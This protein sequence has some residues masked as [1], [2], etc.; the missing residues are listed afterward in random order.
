MKTFQAV[1]TA[2]ALSALPLLA[3]DKPNPQE[4]DKPVARVN[5]RAI[6]QSELDRAVAALKKQFA[7]Y[8]RNVSDE[9]TPQMRYDLL[10][11]MIT[12]E[13]VLEEARGHEA[14]NLTEQVNKQI[15]AAKL[16]LGG[17][18]EFTK[19]LAEMDVSATEY[20]KRVREDLMVRER[21]RQLNESETKVTPEEVKTFYDN[22]RAKMSIPE[23]V[24]ARHILIRVSPDAPEEEKKAKRTQIESLKTLIKE[25]EKFEDVARKYSEDK[26][27]GANGGDLGTFGRGQMVPEFENAAFSLKTNVVSDVVTTQFGY[28]ILLV[29]EHLPAGERSLEDAKADIE[30]YLR[31]A[32]GQQVTADH[33]K[34]LR[35]AA[36]IE[37]LLPKP[38]TAAAPAPA[39]EAKP[40]KPLP[41]VETKPVAAPKP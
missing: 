14:T 25:G 31:Y 30:K 10:Q 21:I 34:K 7:A 15:E 13:L 40:S 5:G 26:G 20:A 27:S 9:Q 4:T 8:G 38:E 6:A 2:L 3:Q 28:H 33:I 36:K 19:A 11:Q 24:S 39:P 32:K 23:R 29:T 1:A 18:E 35:D 17:E 37:I 22:N 12:H 16:Q 41:T